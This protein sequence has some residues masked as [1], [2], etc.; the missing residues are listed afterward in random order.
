MI[1]V[2]QELLTRV[3]LLRKAPPVYRI[4]LKKKGLTYHYVLVTSEDHLGLVA[5]IVPNS[6]AVVFASGGH[7]LAIL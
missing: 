3:S 1:L 4:G 7:L 6:E 2:S 5:A